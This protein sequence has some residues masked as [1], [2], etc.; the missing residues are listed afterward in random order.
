MEKKKEKTIL[1]RFLKPYYFKM[2]DR[3]FKENNYFAFPKYCFTGQA[4]IKKLWGE[5]ERLLK[6][7][8][9]KLV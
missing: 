2:I 9:A 5:V 4:H 7:D 8:I 1:I 3:E 6:N